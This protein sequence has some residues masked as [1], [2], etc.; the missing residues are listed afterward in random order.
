MI[1]TAMV[2]MTVMGCDCD[3]KVCEYI[4]ETPAQW[5]SIADCEAAM[6]VQIVQ[7]RDLDYP[8]ISG[9]CRATEQPAATT[10]A[11]QPNAAAPVPAV[12]FETVGAVRPTVDV[13]ADAETGRGL[14]DRALDSGRL[15][16]RK[17]AGGY[18]MARSGITRAASGT[19]SLV[20]STAQTFALDW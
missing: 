5:A 4:A 10:A 8:L 17:T 20:K 18:D 15:V 7:R 6:R 14:Y 16:F 12:S 3:A 9:L 11:V 2:A 19:M 13:G 1:K